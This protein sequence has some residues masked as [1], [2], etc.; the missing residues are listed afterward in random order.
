MPEKNE[1]MLRDI[2]NEFADDWRVI[3]ETNKD[4]GVVEKLQ[5]NLLDKV[6][7]RLQTLPKQGLEI[8]YKKLLDTVDEN[9][10]P[11]MSTT[12]RRNLRIALKRTEN[13]WLKKGGV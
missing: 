8:D 12:E 3:A 4:V 11:S 10:I 6:E 2:L 5:T 1:K 13:E 7:E 9:V